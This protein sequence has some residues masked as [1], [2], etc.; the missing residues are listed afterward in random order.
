MVSSAMSFPKKDVETRLGFLIVAAYLF[1]IFSRLQEYLAM[2]LGTGFFLSLIVGAA[3]LVVTFTSGT[4]VKGLVSRQGVYLLIFTCWLLLATATS[5]W[6]GGSVAMLT[7]FWF[8]SLITFVLTAALIT[9]LDMTKKAMYVVAVA[10]L[11]AEAAIALLGGNVGGRFELSTGS[12]GNANGLAFHVVLAFPFLYLLLTDGQWIGRIVGTLGL[13]Y[14]MV[15]VIKTGSRSGLIQ[16]CILLFLVFLRLKLTQKILTSVVGISVI[17]IG[18]TSI[19]AATLDRYKTLLTDGGSSQAYDSAMQS[20]MSRWERLTRSLLVTWQHP[21]FGIGPG[22]FASATADEETKEGRVAVW[23]Q[24]HNAYTQLSAEA[25]IPA[26]LLYLLAMATCLKSTISLFLATRKRSDLRMI[27]NM[28]FC[29]ALSLLVFTMNGVTD[30]NAY[31]Y[32]FP[33]L[34]GL[35]LSLTSSAKEY[36]ERQPQSAFAARPQLAQIPMRAP[37]SAALSAPS[38]APPRPVVQTAP[39]ITVRAPGGSRVSRNFNAP[40]V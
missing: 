31:N 13:L 17:A 32:Y 7:G 3:A 24:T 20:G 27:A 6:K 30:S 11:V 36:L 38:K 23:R 10:C 14:G 25:G 1:L 33:F 39:G 19:P 15:V 4:F 9:T 21:L 40:R 8:K 34:A 16:M 26:L 37:V 28:S 5:T 29:L 2:F 18:L 12:L 35:T 22:V